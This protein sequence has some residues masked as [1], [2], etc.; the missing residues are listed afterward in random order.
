MNDALT[1]N[2]VSHDYKGNVQITNLTRAD[3]NVDLEGLYNTGGA[4]VTKA[5]FLSS[6]T[7]SGTGETLDLMG[8]GSLA[9]VA[10]N[11]FDLAKFTFSV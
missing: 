11:S 1:L 2:G 4:L 9:V 7:P 6:L 10:T 5:N 3:P 8:G